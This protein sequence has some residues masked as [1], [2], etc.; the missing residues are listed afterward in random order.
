MSAAL[1]TFMQITTVS[2]IPA[3]ESITSDFLAAVSGGCH[4]GKCCGQ[5]SASATATATASPVIVQLPQLP[6]PAPQPMPAP[7]SGP[8]VSTSVSINGQPAA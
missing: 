3:L 4:K 7:E 6:A 8:Q 1:A 5:A 2:T